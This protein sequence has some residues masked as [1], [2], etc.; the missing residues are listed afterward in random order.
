MAGDAWSRDCIAWV[1]TKTDSLLILVLVNAMG[2][3]LAH[4]MSQV[5]VR[6][7]KKSAFR[8]AWHVVKRIRTADVPG[9]SLQ[10]RVFRV[11]C[12]A[13][14]DCMSRQGPYLSGCLCHG[15]SLRRR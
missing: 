4:G 13:S 5:L 11:L 3:P 10:G 14:V 15:I 6:L 7:W 1:T 12:V 9:V 2:N 8:M